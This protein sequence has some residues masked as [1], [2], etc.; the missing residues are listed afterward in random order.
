MAVPARAGRALNISARGADTDAMVATTRASSAP[1]RSFRLAEP[2]V[3]ASVLEVTTVT[4][5]TMVSIALW[6]LVLPL[7]FVLW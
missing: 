6:L 3:Q 4:V 2:V 1:Q 7:E 5:L